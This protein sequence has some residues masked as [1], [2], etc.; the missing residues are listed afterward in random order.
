MA[1]AQI[2]R[3]PKIMIQTL[4][5]RS[6]IFCESQ[7]DPKAKYAFHCHKDTSISFCEC[8]CGQPRTLDVP[9]EISFKGMLVLLR[10]GSAINT[11]KDQGVDLL[12]EN[13][14]EGFEITWGGSGVIRTAF[15]TYTIAGKVKQ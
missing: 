8:R 6:S 11:A 2:P 9:K 1:F 12:F 10:S 5:L 14:V 7:E 3:L 4:L 13:V 15:K